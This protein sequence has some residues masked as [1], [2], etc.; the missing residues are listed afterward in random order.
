MPKGPKTERADAGTAALHEAQRLHDAVNPPY[1]RALQRFYDAVN[2][3][4]AGFAHQFQQLSESKA[5]PFVLEMQR[6]HD[7]WTP[8][9]AKFAA[10]LHKLGETLAPHFVREMQR[11]HEGFERAN[12]WFTEAPR[13]LRDALQDEAVFPHPDLSISNWQEVLA[14][15]EEAGQQAAIAKLDELHEQLFGSEHFRAD[16]EQRWLKSKR[17]TVLIEILRAHDAGL[18]SVAIPAAITQAEGMVADAILGDGV[19]RKLRHADISAHVIQHLAQSNVMLTPL[20]ETFCSKLFAFFKHGD[21]DSAALERHRVLHG[22][23][24]SYGTRSNSLRAL[25]WLDFV[26]VATMSPDERL[27]A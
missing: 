19:P 12:K 23:S 26:F 8:P 4:F 1:L 10:Q 24:W 6:L 9:L 3:S 7:L 25:V 14:S 21:G 22:A 2:P 18:F 5:P 13:R 27:D 11:L 20:I 15:F 16:L 17:H